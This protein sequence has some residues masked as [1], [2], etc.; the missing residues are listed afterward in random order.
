MAMRIVPTVFWLREAEPAGAA[1]RTRLAQIVPRRGEMRRAYVEAQAGLGDGDTA[2][3]LWQP[4]Y[5]EINGWSEQPSEIGLSLV[6]TGQVRRVGEA[7]AGAPGA[8]ALDAIIARRVE[9]EVWVLDCRPLLE[10]CAQPQAAGPAGSDAG[11]WDFPRVRTS[12]GG[13]QRS[14]NL[15]SHARWCGSAQVQGFIYLSAVAQESNLDLLLRHDQGA[16]LACYHEFAWPGQSGAHAGAQVLQ[17]EDLD[18][19]ERCLERAQPLHD[20]VDYLD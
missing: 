17:G 12:S 14:E 8:A 4:P 11:A 13:A 3:L 15:W 16:W 9:F 6:V 10:I 7:T 1:P 19:I 20:H 5:S 18:V 2:C